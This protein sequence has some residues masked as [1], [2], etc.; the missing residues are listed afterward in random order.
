M[1]RG[2]FVTGTDTGVGKTAVAA[3][4]LCRYRKPKPLTYWKPVQ[5]GSDTDD[6][7]RTVRRLAAA[8]DAEILDRGVR[9]PLPLSPHLAAH[10]VA[11]VLDLATLAQ[12]FVEA[13]PDVRW[14]V[15]GAGGVLTPLNPRERVVDLI[16]K[17][18]LP[19]LVVART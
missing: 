2:L 13:S 18:G 9:L 3:A 8:P 14:V 15:E 6:D 5:T 16:A 1:P 10:R 17:L 4:L 12:P 11:K 19:A 7:T